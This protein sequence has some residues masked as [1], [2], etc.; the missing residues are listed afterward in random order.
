VCKKNSGVEKES[1]NTE[2]TTPKQVVVQ[3]MHYGRVGSRSVTWFHLVLLAGS[4]DA[5]S[6]PCFSRGL[7][8][9]S[10]V[11][12]PRSQGLGLENHSLSFLHFTNLREAARKR[13]GKPIGHLTQDY[14]R[15]CPTVWDISNQSRSSLT[16]RKTLPLES[17]TATTMPE[18]SKPFSLT[19]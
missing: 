17:C 1:P 19:V 11:V 7:L 2:A 9:Q 8:P 3:S 6:T 12:L 5:I 4:V 14:K 16:S 10:V 18:S 15:R 13:Y